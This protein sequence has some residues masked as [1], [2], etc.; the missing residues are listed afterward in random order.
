MCYVSQTRCR[1][2][3]YT[4]LLT[5]VKPPL[6]LMADQQ[7]A[8]HFLRYHIEGPSISIVTLDWVEVYYIQP[9]CWHSVCG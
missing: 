4:Q 2:D 3:C 1:A 7:S 6:L 8:C 9:S 5:R